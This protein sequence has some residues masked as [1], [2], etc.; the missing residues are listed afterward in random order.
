MI[1]LMYVCD[2]V[3][4]AMLATCRAQF[5]AKV[6]GYQASV[7]S[8]KKMLTIV[9]SSLQSV[10]VHCRMRRLMPIWQPRKQLMQLR[11]LG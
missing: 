11:W 9:V 3:D 2:S 6:T 7:I 10:Q 1:S 4:P 8:E 5:D